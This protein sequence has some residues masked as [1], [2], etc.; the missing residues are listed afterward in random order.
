VATC[1]V[2]LVLAD[3]GHGVVLANGFVRAAVPINEP[4]TKFFCPLAW[5]RSKISHAH[6]PA[7]HRCWARHGRDASIQAGKELK[8]FDEFS[9]REAPTIIGQR[10][11]ALLQNVEQHTVS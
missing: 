10:L 5:D 7:M 11:P 8:L 1:A 4:N 3:L 9:V 6:P 2:P